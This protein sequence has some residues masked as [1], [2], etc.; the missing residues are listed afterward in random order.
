MIFY[1][2][3]FIQNIRNRVDGLHHFVFLRLYLLK[4]F[5][6]VFIQVLQVMVEFVLY[7]KLLI[8][9]VV[10]HLLM[11]QHLILLLVYYHQHY[12]II[13]FFQVLAIRQI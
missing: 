9:F 2:H 5:L 3:Y 11:I 10:M 6:L 7:Q 4:N 12:Y 8:H 1:V 13:Q